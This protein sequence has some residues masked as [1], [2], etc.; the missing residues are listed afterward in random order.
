MDQE[1]DH[2][3]AQQDGSR[4]LRMRDLTEDAG[5][6]RQ[7]IHFYIEEGLLPPPASKRSNSAVYSQVHLERLRWIKRLQSEHFLSLSAIKSVLNG[8]DLG[9]FTPKQKELLR[10]VRDQLPEW[11]Q[12]TATPVARIPDVTS[13]TVTEEDLRE[14]QHAGL[15][16]LKGTGKNRSISQDDAQIIECL[17]RYKEA[18]ATRERGYRPAY[19]AI[20]DRAIDNI[21]QELSRIYSRNWIDADVADAA[22]FADAMFAIDERL[23]GVLLRKK[24][25][26]FSTRF[27]K[28]EGKPV[29]GSRRPKTSMK[30]GQGPNI[31]KRGKR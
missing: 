28:D 6:T 17:A 19:L 30:S 3:P 23:M 11:A 22:A 7:A 8:E 9:D 16:D 26:N 2:L 25:R 12:L 10:R 5:L 24:M 31:K 21:V 13:K 1:T 18:G 15:I 4:P 14:L 20:I 29:P 27:P